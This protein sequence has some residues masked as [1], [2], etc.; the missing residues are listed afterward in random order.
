MFV[1]RKIL[2]EKLKQILA[3]DI[4]L[5]DVTAAAVV[6]SGLTAQAAVSAKE[7]GTVAG[8][9]EAVVLAESLGLKVKVE[10]ADGDEVRKGQVLLKVSGDARAILSVERTL[11]NLVSRMSGIATATRLLTEKLRKAHAK[12]KIAAT[13][14]SAP[15][16][17]YFDKKAVF[18]GGGDPHR[19][20]LSDM[21]LVK[22]NHIALAGSVENAVKNAQQNSSFSKKIEVE[23]ARVADVLKTA[24]T[25]ADI[26]MFDNFSPKQIKEAIEL[27]KETGFYGKIL[28]EASGE[29]TEDNL[30]EYAALPVD[31]ISMGRLTHSIKALNVSLEITKVG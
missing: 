7:A 4:G 11:L 6:P 30:L 3:E 1:P 15:G 28:L 19:L 10:V 9:E 20:N 2:E 24:K 16:L 8:V 22:D 25:G 17:L 29:I 21:I 31:I 26:I 18:I 12:A 27:L 13:R 5:G 23:V 14:K